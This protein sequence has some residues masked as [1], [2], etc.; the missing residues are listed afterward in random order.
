LH[1]AN[2]GVQAVSGK[3]EQVDV[4]RWLTRQQR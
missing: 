1:G 2:A 4:E 3:M